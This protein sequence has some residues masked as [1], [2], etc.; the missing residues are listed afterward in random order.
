MTVPIE[1]DVW[2]GEIA[3]LEVDAILIPANESL[4]MT[5]RVGRAVRLHAGESVERD[6]VQ[7]GPVEAGTAVVT[8]GGQLSAPYVVHVVGVGHDLRPDLDRLRTALEAGLR[9]ASRLGLTRLAV[10]PIG[11]ERGVFGVEQAA[12]ALIEVLS[13]RSV[14]AD[15]LP[16]SLVVAV[17]GPAEAAAYR[18]ALAALA[19]REAAT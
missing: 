17:S 14:E 6:A 4:F 13:A 9:L 10:A 11:T 3:E 5:T 2:Q 18:S 19:S 16:A 8:A 12:D 1:I 15:G 7:Q